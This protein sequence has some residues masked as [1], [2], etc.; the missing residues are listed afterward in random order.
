MYT[1]T[2]I[3]TNGLDLGED[4]QGKGRYFTSK[5]LEPGLAKYDEPIG[6]ILL[7]KET[8]DKFIT[9]FKGCPVIIDHKDITDD[10]AKDERVG[11]VSNVWYN[12]D[13]GWYYC[14]GVIFDKNAQGL[15]TNAGYTVS[16]AY[17]F[18]TDEMSG[19]WHNNPYDS[20]VV[21][22]DFLHLALVPVP[23]YED[24]TIA[25][26]SKGDKWITIR[27]NGEENKGK[28]LLLKEGETPKEAI[29][30]SYGIEMKETSSIPK[31]N[32][33]E[34]P[35]DKSSQNPEY[36]PTKKQDDIDFDR[37]LK[38][39]IKEKEQKG[40]KNVDWEG[41][42]YTL[43]DLINRGFVPTKYTSSI[44]KDDHKTWLE[45]EDKGKLYRLPI[46][47]DEFDYLEPLYKKKI[48]KEFENVDY[49][50]G[51]RHKSEKPMSI[52]ELKRDRMRQ[53]NNEINLDEPDARIEKDEDMKL[54][55]LWQLFNKKEAMNKKG[56]NEMAEKVDKRKLIDEIGGILKGK[57]DDELIRTIIKKAEEIG[58]EDSEKS[59]D[60]KAKNE[61]DE[62]DKKEDKAENKCAKNEDEDKD[63]DKKEADNE[64]EDKME[65]M[66][67]A[68]N[69]MDK[70][71]KAYNSSNV[72]VKSLYTPQSERVEL[73]KQL[74]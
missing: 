4:R 72:Q 53:A 60:N 73:G 23:R 51:I 32:P 65:E 22:G 59:A 69:S 34:K 37:I 35:M 74:F 5:F 14:D 68:E 49:G 15:I 40:E 10:T 18:N 24:A 16:C 27:P 21:S 19:T 63:E 7:D 28:H 70:M 46:S 45:K 50:K 17:S 20:K 11:V 33:V 29:E 30:R 52:I 39:K 12:A 42:Q 64:D 67:K 26:N 6:T 25:L 31:V 48:N 2:H 55:Q 62:E 43:A 54:N 1:N 41:K 58:Y 9:S 38:E 71:R 47:Q 44:F 56:E 13:D 8:I 57:V 66:K 61:A 3:I 36:K